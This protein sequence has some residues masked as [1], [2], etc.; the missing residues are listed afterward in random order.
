MGYRRVENALEGLR[1]VTSTIILMFRSTK[2]HFLLPMEKV[3]ERCRRPGG[4][5]SVCAPESCSWSLSSQWCPSSKGSVTV[6]P[7][8]NTAISHL[9]EVACP[10]PLEL[11][12]WTR[13]IKAFPSSFWSKHSHPSVPPSPKF[14]GG[15]TSIASLMK[16]HREFA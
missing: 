3:V 10:A 14:S 8:A 5:C 7:P 9:R 4:P 11:S 12:H 1:E 16:P 13:E 6:Q 15:K 2:P